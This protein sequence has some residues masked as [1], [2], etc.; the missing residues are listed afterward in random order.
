MTQQKTGQVRAS[1]QSG[2][3]FVVNPTDCY[4]W[5]NDGHSYLRAKKKSKKFSYEYRKNLRVDGQDVIKAYYAKG[6]GLS[7]SDGGPVTPKTFHR[8]AYTLVD[9]NKYMLV[10]YFDTET[11]GLKMVINQKEAGDK[12]KE[13]DIGEMLI[14]MP[15]KMRGCKRRLG[16]S[17]SIAKIRR[18]V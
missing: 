5:R 1:P 12:G 2:D 4:K 15:L 16:R 11:E 3:F 6:S 18:K 17:K 13:E 10:H 14:D 9:F 8:R 7:K